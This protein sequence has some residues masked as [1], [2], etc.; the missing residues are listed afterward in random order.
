MDTYYFTTPLYYVNARP[1]IGHAYTTIVAD[2]LTRFHRLFGADCF[3]LTGTDEHGENIAAKAAEAGL[4]PQDFVNGVSDEF[5]AAWKDLDIHYDR[6]IRTTD[7]DHET[8]VQKMLQKIHDDGHIYRNDY[9]GRYCRGCERYLDDSDLDEEGR[10]RDH[11]KAPEEVSEANYFF[12]MSAF[13]DRLVRHIEENPEFIFPEA[14]RREVLG[15]LREPLHD[16]CISRP[17]ARLTWGIDLPFDDDFVTYVWFD[18]LLNYVSAHGGPGTGSHDRWWPDVH[19]L[20]AKDIVKTHCI[21]WPTMLM[22]LGIDLPKKFVV[23]GYWNINSGKISKTVGNVVSP[24]DLT[25]RF[26][27]DAVR[28]YLMAAMSFGQ[29]AD[30]TEELFVERYNADLANTLGNLAS[31]TL[32]LTVKNFDGTVPASEPGVRERELMSE[33]EGLRDR[34]HEDLRAFRLHK[35]AQSPVAMGKV[36]NRYIDE[37]EPWKLAKDPDRREDLARVLGMQ[38]RCLRVIAGVVEPVM[39]DLSRR[40]F[41]ALGEPESTGG[42]IDWNLPEA[43]RSI[44]VVPPLF[45]RVGTKAQN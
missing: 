39:P 23:H 31:R 38:C 32:T 30:F 40:L 26:G 21:Y 8:F 14:Y 15:F 5:K 11:L 9:T 37:H 28:Y 44:S 41:E 24:L 27:R 45:P 13:Q 20:L 34:M 36:V 1:H 12:R 25:E 18:A 22:A 10:C 3:F 33:L 42:E 2:V 7:A 4:E 43:G 19:H 17:K 6:F 16:L 35:V 29:D